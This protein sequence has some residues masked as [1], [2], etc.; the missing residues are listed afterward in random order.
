MRRKK[1]KGGIG[2]GG[3]GRGRGRGERKGKCVCTRW[4]GSML[5]DWKGNVNMWENEKKKLDKTIDR[6][7][8]D[9]KMIDEE[10]KK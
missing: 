3:C 5:I 6:D 4:H 1:K 7:R 2:G 8:K 10:E 9:R